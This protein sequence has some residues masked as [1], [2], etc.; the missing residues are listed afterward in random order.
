MLD[1]LA[2]A[3]SLCLTHTHTLSLSQSLTLTLSLSQH[4]RICNGAWIEQS[5]IASHAGLGVQLSISSGRVRVKNM[6]NG[7][8]A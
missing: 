1:L 6:K 4:D 7:Y 3:R 2:G 5:N 8:V